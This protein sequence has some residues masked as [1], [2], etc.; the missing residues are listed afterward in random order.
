MMW[1]GRGG[2]QCGTGKW[3]IMMCVRVC[4]KSIAHFTLMSTFKCHFEL[5]NS[6]S[7]TPRSVNSL[8]GEWVS[9]WVCNLQNIHQKQNESQFVG[10]EWR[11]IPANVLLHQCWTC[12]GTSAVDCLRDWKVLKWNLIKIHL[13]KV[14]W[15]FQHELQLVGSRFQRKG[16]CVLFC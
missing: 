14:V 8:V 11:L 6:F 7:F 16:G 4:H 2:T 9:E 13:S 10:S 3:W 1:G 15:P 5:R 12:D